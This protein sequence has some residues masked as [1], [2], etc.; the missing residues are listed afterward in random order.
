MSLRVGGGLELRELSAAPEDLDRLR[1]FYERLYVGEFP[2]AD[3]RES[4]KNIERYLR[5]KAEGWY[6]RNNYH[7]LLVLD[8]EEPVAGSISDYLAEVNT[9]VIEFL[10]VA[11]ARRRDGLGRRL[12]EWTEGKLAGDAQAQ[13]RALDAV[14]GEMN[15]PFKSPPGDSLD[16]FLRLRVW[17]AWGYAKLDFPY[18]QPA[19]SA[20]Q[21]PVPHLLLSMKA[22]PARSAAVTGHLVRRIVHEYIRWAMRIED[23]GQSAEYQAMARYLAQHDRVALVPLGVYTGHDPRRPLAVHPITSVTAPALEAALAVYA[24]A[25][26]PGPT[27]VPPEGFRRRLATDRHPDQPHAYHLWAL[28]TS[29][30][31]PVAGMTSFFTIPG[32]GF[33]GYVAFGP[34]LRG[35]ARLP[36]LLARIEAQMV[37]DGFGARGWYIECAHESAAVPLF[38]RAGFRRVV[39]DYRQP[40][41]GRASGPNGVSL[42]LLYKDFGAVHGE[43][44]VT[45]RAFLEALTCMYRVVYEVARPREH[46]LYRSLAAKLA[47]H[48]TLAFA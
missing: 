6:G 12:L 4:L 22:L 29:P 33:G 20:Q 32:A 34:G 48:E 5:L 41:L 7:V 16:P 14:I 46:A 31:A 42:A 35:T 17:D 23:P 10:V 27:T 19:L 36:L 39:I 2:D 45:V 15:D 25:F 13:G 24:S 8:G 47:G 37:G 44:V 30:Q 38:R 26:P 40:S 43:P 3:E 11:P 18:V 9:G 28:A 1:L 21:E